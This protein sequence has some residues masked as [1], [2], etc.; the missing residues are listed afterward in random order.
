MSDEIKE[1]DRLI[2]LRMIVPYSDVAA[3][4]LEAFWSRWEV[5]VDKSRD[6][7]HAAAKE[8][9]ALELGEA[10]I[11]LPD[12]SRWVSAGSLLDVDTFDEE[13]ESDNSFLQALHRILLGHK[14]SQRHFGP[15]LPQVFLDAATLDLHSSFCVDCGRWVTLGG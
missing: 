5:E 1:F 6:A 2:A 7:F 14:V 12:G 13:F 11:R 3:E 10:V 15:L 4:T 8:Y 9:E